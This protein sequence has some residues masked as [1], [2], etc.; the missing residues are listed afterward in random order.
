M[1]VVARIPATSPSLLVAPQVAVQVMARNTFETHWHRE[2]GTGSSS[3][4]ARAWHDGPWCDRAAKSKQGLR[5][6]TTRQAPSDTASDRGEWPG[7]PQH[8][9]QSGHF[10]NAARR[11]RVLDELQQTVLTGFPIRPSALRVFNLF[12]M[13]PAWG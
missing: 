4:V 6:A 5:V 12:H 2:S 3:K 7:T 1:V 10:C 9:V 11:G 8:V 13:R